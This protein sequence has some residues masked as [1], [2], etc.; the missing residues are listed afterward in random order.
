[1]L[2]QLHPVALRYSALRQRLPDISEKVLVSTLRI[3]EQDDLVARVEAGR[4]VEYALTERGRLA[5][6]LI[7][8][9]AA[10]SQAYRSVG[11]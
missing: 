9:L 4:V 5:L 3:L 7:D 6:P 2:H 11:G 8:Q 10:F 1:M